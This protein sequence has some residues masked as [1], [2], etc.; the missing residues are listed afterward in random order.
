MNDPLDFNIEHFEH[1]LLEAIAP[2][3][4]EPI[5]LHYIF[6]ALSEYLILLSSPR[7]IFYEGF[8]FEEA[9]TEA[10]KANAR[11]KDLMRLFI[12]NNKSDCMSWTLEEIMAKLHE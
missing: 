3:H 5:T 1:F 6:E 2:N 7:S 12:A 11:R 4:Q 8:E 9:M 10:A